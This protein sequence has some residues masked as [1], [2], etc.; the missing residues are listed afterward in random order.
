MAEGAAHIRFL[1]GTDLR[2]GSASEVVLDEFVYD[3][4][5]G[6]GAFTVNITKGV[7]RLVTGKLAGRSFKVRTPTAIVSVRGTDF[8]VAVLASGL[9]LIA[10]LVGEVEIQ[11]AAGGDASAVGAG[12]TGTVAPGATQVAVVAGVPPVDEELADDA[13]LK[14]ELGQDGNDDGGGGAD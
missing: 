14:G 4:S 7:L 10:V 5:G 6:A 11:P 9:T 12:N 13:S 1:D 2:V 8:I 3:A